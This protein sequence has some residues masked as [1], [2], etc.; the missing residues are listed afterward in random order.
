MDFECAFSLENQD[1]NTADFTVSGSDTEKSAKN[2][3]KLGYTLAVNTGM[4]IGDKAAATI[5]PKT[6]GLVIAT[7][8]SCSVSNEEEDSRVK[9]FDSNKAPQTNPLGVSI[10]VGSGKDILKFGWSSFKWS[11][12]KVNDKD[13]IKDQE[14]S[15]NIGLSLKKKR[16]RKKRKKSLKV[17]V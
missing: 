14:L 3:G 4:T 8:N 12:T 13:V 10:D 1:L 6:K 16:R 11:T 17:K 2:T 5:T 7:V 15:C 9:L